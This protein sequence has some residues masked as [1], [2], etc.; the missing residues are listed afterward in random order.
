VRVDL[1]PVDVRHPRLRG[2]VVDMV[3]EAISHH[4]RTVRHVD[5]LPAEARL[6]PRTASGGA[7]VVAAV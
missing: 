5:L 2:A 1:H 7:V 6:A 3:D 4:G